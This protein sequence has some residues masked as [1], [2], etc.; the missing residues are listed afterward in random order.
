MRTLR[1]LIL[2]TFLGAPVLAQDV[3]TA[4]GARIESAEVTGIALDQLS[5]G[6]QRDIDALAGSKLE[7]ALVNRLADRIEEEH[8]EVV[9]AVRT[10]ARADGQVRVL[11]LVAR[12]SDDGG[13]VS[14]INARYTVESVEIRGIPEDDISRG[15]RDRLQG[16]VGGRLDPDDADDL[17]GR[18]EAEKP[19]YDVSRRISRGS[20]RGQIHVVFEFERTERLRWIPFAQSRSKFVFHSDEGVGAV[21]DIPIGGGDHRV[22]LGWA[23]DNNDDLVEEYSGGRVRFETRH[24]GTD[25]VGASLELSGFHNDWRLE[26]VAALAANPAIPARYENRVTVEPAVTVALTRHLRVSGGLSFSDLDPISPLPDSQMASAVVGSI[27]YGQRW[28]TEGDRHE[29]DSRQNVEA[30]YELRASS[31]ALESDFCYKRHFGHARY[32]FDLNH[33]AVIADVVVGRITGQAPLFERFSLG[34]TSTLRGWNKFDIAPAGGDHVFHQS[35]EY[36]Y[37]GIG[38]FLD[39]GSIWDTGTERHIRTSAG[40]GVITD[41]FFLTVGFPLGTSRSGAAVMSGVKF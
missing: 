34:D 31:S 7:T 14:N 13:L 26:T 30:S 22:T 6:L 40:F 10:M 16:L 39:A 41:H 33:H 9:A 29:E 19:G 32:K 20:R 28:R 25:R 8:P 2:L 37:H 3:D 24:I 15:L 12:I 38:L 5:G 35:I 4:D 27:A 23:A 18:L 21:H 36:R 1:L 17:I 11:F